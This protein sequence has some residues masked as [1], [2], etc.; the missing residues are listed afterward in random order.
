MIDTHLIAAVCN[1]DLLANPAVVS[2]S[3]NS[4][5]GLSVRSSTAGATRI[6]VSVARV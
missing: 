4:N 3:L 2:A 1:G 5:D 6:N